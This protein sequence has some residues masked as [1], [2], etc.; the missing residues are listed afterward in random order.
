M[1]TREKLLAELRR[2]TPADRAKVVVMAQ[3]I[4]TAR[5]AGD[6]RSASEIVVPLLATKARSTA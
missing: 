1:M 2:L 6:K 4:R 3:T 5:D